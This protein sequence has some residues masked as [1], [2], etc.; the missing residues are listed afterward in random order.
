M[1]NLQETALEHSEPEL[2][3]LTLYCQN[4]ALVNDMTPPPQVHVT[5]SLLSTVQKT[6]AF[7]AKRVLMHSSHLHHSADSDSQF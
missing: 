2:F 1:D 3:F 7:N 6:S 4:C 5:L